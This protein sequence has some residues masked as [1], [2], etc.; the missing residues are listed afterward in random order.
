M[1]YA[2]RRRTASI[3][4]ATGLLILTG[5]LFRTQLASVFSLSWKDDRYVTLGLA[6]LLCAFVLYWERTAIFAEARLS[7]RTGIV[8]TS[9]SMILA[10]TLVYLPWPENAGARLALVLSAIVLIW[11][12]VFIL[13]CG[14]QSFRKAL[15]ALCCLFLM[16]PIPSAMMDWMTAQLQQG[17]AATSFQILRLLGIPVYREG[18]IFMLPGLVFRVAPECSGIHSWLAFVILAVLATRVFLRSRWTMLALI[19]LTVPIAILKN[20]IRIVVIASLTAY[21]DRSIINSPLHH[22]GGPLFA[23]IDLAIFIPLMILSQ[24]IE[25]RRRLSIVSRSELSAGTDSAVNAAR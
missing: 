15:F 11:I 9:L 22:N 19:L 5:A 2:P 13:C 25:I 18:M 12:S 10:L 14:L 17:S 1:E 20:S 21:V 4:L 3:L 16:I 23:L 24:K 8:F 6:P 7:P